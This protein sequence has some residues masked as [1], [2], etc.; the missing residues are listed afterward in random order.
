VR[1]VASRT[2]LS[3]HVLRAWERRYGVVSPTR[4]EGGQRLYSDLDIE[5]LLRLRRLA[6]RGHSIG[7]I[8]GLELPEL[9]ELE[10]ATPE[11]SP[12][13]ALANGD[14]AP[15]ASESAAHVVAAALLAI[16]RLDA[17]ELQALL[18]RSAIT[19]GVPVLLDRVLTPLLERVGHGWSEGW[20]SVAQEHLA[21]AVIRRVLGWLLRLYEASGAAPRLVVATPSHHA[22]EL[23]AL[24]VAASAA[25]EGWS[26]TY[27]GPDLPVAELLAAAEQTGARV[28]AI[29]AVH[30][31]QAGDLLGSVRETRARLPREVA[32]V[33]GGAAALE[34]RA[35]IEA[36]GGRV[37]ESL[38]EF[39]A[40]LPRL[41]S[42]DQLVGGRQ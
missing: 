8:A 40:L 4:S 16:R 15:A 34:R 38:T 7:R 20:L 14:G 19:L 13:P 2:G 36:A 29:S 39:R 28:V 31:P 11:V 6:E 10:K 21:S 42:Y 33:V 1:L 25:A 9:V 18:E 35:E 27:L 12:T 5:R 37:I 26:V 22:H 3:A 24:M 30:E 17:G 41:A 32:L 23:G